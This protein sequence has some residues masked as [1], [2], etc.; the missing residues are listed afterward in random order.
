MGRLC[1]ESASLRMIL[2]SNPKAQ[3][4]AHKYEIDQAVGHVFNSGWYILGEE[5]QAFEEEFAS[6]IGVSQSI[7]VGNGTDALHLAL[8][9]CGVGYGDEVITVSHSAVATIASIELT[10][11][12]PVLVDIEPQYFTMDPKGFEKAITKKTKAVIPVHI[13]GQPVDLD[14]ILDIAHNHNIYV[15][16]DCAQAHGARYKGKS[17][18]SFGDIAC[19]SFYP[20]KNLG[21]L[22]DGGLVA[23]NNS[24]LGRRA[25][26]LREY[27][28]AER[29]I[30]HFAGWNTRLDELQAAIL[31][32]KLHYLDNDNETRRRIA[33][34]YTNAFIDENL[35]L[36]AIRP[37][38]DHVFHLY[39]IRSE[40]RNR[41]QQY[42]KQHD[43][44]TGIH[45]PVP[46]HLQ[47]AYKDR[48][49]GCDSLP[50]TEKLAPE[51]LSLPMYPEL[52]M[53]Q[54][55]SIVDAVKSFSG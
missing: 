2:C 5:T 15:I 6:Y 12:T 22:G 17:V 53:T 46:I 43:I 23:T 36:P 28:W 14:P 32:V 11:A 41:L 37:N 24:D 19:F 40:K 51:L 54:L 3:Y 33:N 1:T 27:G 7:G 9:T 10:G 47:P 49:P 38:C 50:I 55:Q 42:L 16:E 21:A 52:S 8:V 34:H 13:Y 39:V 29:Y 45:Y 31:R 48:L 26:L 35:I 18:G 20:T 25:R 30:S 44:S 4:L